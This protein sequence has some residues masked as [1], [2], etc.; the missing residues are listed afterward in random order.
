M[1]CLG[2]D[3]RVLH[4]LDVHNFVGEELLLTLEILVGVEEGGLRGGKAALSLLDGGLVGS[5]VNFEKRIARLH[6]CALGKEGLGQQT[7]DLWGDRDRRNGRAVAKRVEIDL[8][9]AFN[10]RS[11]RDGRGRRRG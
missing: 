2:L 8:G 9:T 10:D 6:G 7:G 3:L 1:S 11:Y 5:R 4:G